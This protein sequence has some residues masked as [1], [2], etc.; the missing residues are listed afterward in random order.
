MRIICERNPFI[1][2]FKIAA[3]FASAKSPKP[4]LQSVKLRASGEAAT[5]TATDFEISVRVEVSGVT[6]SEPGEVLLPVDRISQILRESS[7]PTLEIASIPSGASVKGERSAFN[8]PTENPQEFPDIVSFIAA[9]GD[10]DY[11]EVTARSFCEYAGRVL[12]AVDE[13]SSRYALGGSL[14]ELADDKIFLVATDGRRLAKVEGTATRVGNP[15]SVDAAAIVPARSMRLMKQAFAD[16]DDQL[17]ITGR[18]NEILVRG[19][20]VTICSRLLEGRFPKWRDVFPRRQ[21]EKIELQAGPLQLA[22]RQ[23]AIV[24]SDESRGV[25]FSFST[26]LLELS[27]N[28]A[29]RGAS[30]VSL[31]VDYQG[32][33]I[34]IT[35]NPIFLIDYLKA[36]GADAKFTLEIKDRSSPVVCNTKDGYSYVIMPL[37]RD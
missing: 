5:L 3:G 13:A 17:A 19:S 37:S 18:P 14:L 30:S 22:A 1:S 11:H 33:A 32:P 34:S 27:A 6:V 10:S 23:A 12:Y 20:R 25:D 29:E 36:I 4:I 9:F 28:V 2:S 21:D 24:T 31:P 16:T 8:L 35:L 7:D 15:K 26:G